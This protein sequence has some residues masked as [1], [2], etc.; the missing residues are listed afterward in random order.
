[1][2]KINVDL[3]A[4]YFCLLA[5]DYYSVFCFDKDMQMKELASFS[6]LLRIYFIITLQL[7][8]GSTMHN[9]SHYRMNCA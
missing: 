4:I 8:Y 7:N 3:F 2:V 6:E 1:V 9:T 5:T